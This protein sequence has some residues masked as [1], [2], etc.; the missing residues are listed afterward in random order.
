MHSIGPAA[1]LAHAC[2]PSDVSSAILVGLYYHG[3]PVA[4]RDL[5]RGWYEKIVKNKGRT[6][7][8]DQPP[9]I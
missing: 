6:I 4:R 2:V 5:I 9:F 8:N 3:V 7:M 1:C